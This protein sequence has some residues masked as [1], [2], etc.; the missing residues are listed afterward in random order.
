VRARL[1]FRVLLLTGPGT[2]S[3]VVVDVAHLW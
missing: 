3:R 2:H 1:P